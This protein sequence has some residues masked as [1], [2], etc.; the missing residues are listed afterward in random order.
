MGGTI[1]RARSQSQIAR[2]L[3]PF[4]WFIVSRFIVAAK[5]AEDTLGYPPTLFEIYVTLK[6]QSVTLP[7]QFGPYEASAVMLSMLREDIIYADS[8]AYRWSVRKQD[9]FFNFTELFQRNYGTDGSYGCLPDGR[10]VAQKARTIKYSELV[11]ILLSKDESVFQRNQWIWDGS[12]RFFD[13]SEKIGAGGHNNH[14]QF[15][16]FPRSGNSFLRRLVEQLTGITTGSIF[17]LITATSMQI[18]GM[19]G[20]KHIGDEIWVCKTHH[21]MR[22]FLTI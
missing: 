7:I 13:K 8:V 20:E 4:P 16:S 18:V 19:K 9:G 2:S 17:P 5:E 11:A 12:F 15:T 3:V 10:I 22:H 21:P 1:C 6:K 14:I